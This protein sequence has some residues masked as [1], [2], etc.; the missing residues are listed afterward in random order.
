[1]KV[2][3]RS[4]AILG[5]LEAFPR[6]LAVREIAKRRGS[7][8]RGIST[9]HRNSRLRPSHGAGLAGRAKIAHA[10]SERESAGATL[11][12][13][14]RV[15]AIAR[16][17]AAIRDRAADL[18][19]AALDQSGL[20]AETFDRL[21]LFD[22]FEFSEEPFGFRDLVAAKQY[23]RLIGE[24]LDWH[25]LVRAIRSG[26]VA[27]P[28]GSLANVRLERSSWNDV[29]MRDGAA[30]TELSG[31][32]LLALAARGA[33]LAPTSSSTRRRRRRRPRLGARER[34]LR[35]M[36]GDRAARS[37]HRLQPQPR[38]DAAG[39]AGS[40]RGATSQR[41]STLDKNYAE[42]WYNLAA[43]AREQKDIESARRNLQKSIAADP[44]Y[45]DPV[46][47]LALLE[48]E[49]G[50]HE[51]ATRLWQKYRELDPDSSWGRK[52]KQGLQLIAPDG[53]P[54]RRACRATG[55]AGPASA[56]R[57]EFSEDRPGDS[58]A[59]VR[60]G[61]R[62]RRADGHAVHEGVRQRR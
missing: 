26:R 46:Y 17:C 35:K 1:M 3:G 16:P 7:L 40:R 19:T 32:H 22:A 49:T 18:R 31:Q 25:G 60:P 20:D 4:F 50:D 34:A 53:K 45:P 11:D 14:E 42:A 52:A 38:A 62:R 54:S 12:Q 2:E 56:W 48:F 21:R 13:R 61:A 29:L 10:S 33:R 47:N 6:R 44:T 27:A 28:G 37:G 51:E 36:P 55:G 15:P 30:L 8:Q 57:D 41:C 24:G 43:I 9:T 58:I 59:Q 5:A 23:A 39:R